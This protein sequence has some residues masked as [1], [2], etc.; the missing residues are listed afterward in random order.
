MKR[1]LC[2][3]WRSAITALLL[4][5]ACAAAAS[6]ADDCIVAAR[7][8]FLAG[9]KNGLARQIGCARGRELEPYVEYWTL[10]LRMDEMPAADV[11]EFL[12][13]HQGSLL[14][15]RLRA[16]WL[17]QLGMSLRWDEFEREYPALVYADA[18][19]ACYALQSRLARHDTTALSEARGMWA[20]PNL[21]LS[22]TPVLEALVSQG[23]S[24]DEVWR[25]LHRLLETKH[26]PAARLTATFLPG[27]QRPDGK[28]LERVIDAP[29]TY[30][31]KLKPNFSATRTGRELAMA[32]LAQMARS[33]PEA[34]AQSFESIQSKFSAQERA[35]VYG[36]LAWQAA[37][38]H[39][40][41]AL[42]WFKAAGDTPMC[43]QQL[44]WKARAGLRALDW[45]LVLEA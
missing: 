42:A 12:R 1:R 40:P 7:E 39:L 29:A 15:E 28:T 36:Q 30:L 20:D 34:T 8:A 24:I 25:R 31:H 23:V 35:Y 33:D 21:P 17:K 10:E 3:S 13:H 38:K 16:D 5:Y 4:A 19:I 2:G 18:E 11:A 6:G 27:E 43:H 9:D 45:R 26:L 22:C 37:L 32:A 44:A 41:Q 14:A